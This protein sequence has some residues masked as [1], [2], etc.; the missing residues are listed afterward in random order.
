M[1]SSPSRTW[2]PEMPSRAANGPHG[3]PTI[4]TWSMGSNSRRSLPAG[5]G[6]GSGFASK[7]VYDNGRRVLWFRS[8]YAALYL[9]AAGNEGDIRILNDAGDETIRLDGQSGDIELVSADCAEEFD[10]SDPSLAVPGAVMVIGDEGRLS[11]CGQG[12]DTRVAGVISGAGS[13]RSGVMLDRRLDR[14]DRRP[15][16]LVGKVLALVDADQ[17][18]VSVGD[19]LT[20]SA[21]PGHAMRATDPARAFGAVLGKALQGL[22]G[23]TGLVPILVSLQ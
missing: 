11:P 4:H 7:T 10:I 20:T 6:A 2:P 15:L 21:T 9:G 17:D 18:P 22:D 12:Y 16:A 8:Q 13:F 1:T 3:L 19:V 5:H 14:V 23:G